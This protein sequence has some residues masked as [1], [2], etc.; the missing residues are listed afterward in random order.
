MMAMALKKALRAQIKTVV[1]SLSPECIQQQSEAIAAHVCAC[2][3]YA[4]AR[5][6][7]VYISF[8]EEVETVQFMEDILGRKPT[9]SEL[10]LFVPFM[11]D[12]KASSMTFVEVLP[13]PYVMCDSLR[14]THVV[15]S[16]TQPCQGCAVPACQAF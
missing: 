6:V 12:V 1:Q 4:E 10:R 11:D 2:G 15:H 7:G 3:W 8:A 13:H 9:I 16:H 14:A 5:R